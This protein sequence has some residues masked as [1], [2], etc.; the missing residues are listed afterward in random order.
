MIKSSDSFLGLADT[1]WITK[2]RIDVWHLCFHCAFVFINRLSIASFCNTCSRSLEWFLEVSSH[3]YKI[4][5]LT[6]FF[7]PFCV[8]LSLSHSLL[9]LP[10]IQGT[11]NLIDEHLG[12]ENQTT[13]QAIVTLA[14]TKFYVA[15]TDVIA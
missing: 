2:I 5:G 9:R 8:A 7:L 3:C 1:Q 10:C 4:E 13:F 12:T 15:N 14:P 11:M 6:D